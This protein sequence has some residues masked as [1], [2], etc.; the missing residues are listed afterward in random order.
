MANPGIVRNPSAPQVE[1]STIAKLRTIAVALL[2]D[3][4]H[5]NCGSIGLRP[6]HAPAPMA[7]TAVTVKTRGGDNLAILRA[8][9]FC[10]PGDV[11]VV[12]AG[13]DTTNALVGGIMTFAAAS[14]G[15]AGMVL[16]GAIRDAAEIGARTFP[17][18]A[19]G[20]SHRGPYKDGPG[21]INV[22]ITVGGM[23]VNPG[24]VIVGDQDG[25]LA[26]QPALA[27]S[28]IEKALAQHQKEEATMQ[29]IRDGR[30]D[31]SFVDVLEARCA[32]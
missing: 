1:P 3:Q 5:R 24:D 31:R 28:V 19:R 4:L 15:L 21:E 8:Y 32:N 7:G 27:A 20:V 16:D 10:R 6:Y 23:V 29:A 30:W 22:P 26:F 17:V 25:L 11:M 13:G 9:D 18:Y 14:L 2:S 12:D